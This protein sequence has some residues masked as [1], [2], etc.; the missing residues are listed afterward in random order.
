VKSP[1]HKLAL[2]VD[3]E[4]WYHSRR[5][6]DGE[7]ARTLPD[8]TALFRK[9]Y[10]SDRPAGEIIA[11]TLALLEL[12]ERHRCRATFFVLGEIARYY[13]DLVRRI[14]DA[15]HELACHG[16]YH[17]DMTVLGP[18]RFAEQL[19]EAVDLIQ[20]L[21]GLKPVGYRGPNLVYSPWAT[22]IL[23]D[24]GFLY[25]STV[26][27]SRPLGG[28]YAGWDKAPTH[29]YRASYDA[30]EEP[31]GSR[32]VE[33]PLPA[34][35]WIKLAGGSGITTRI[36]GYYWSLGALGHAIRRGNTAYYF[37]P[38]EV[39]TRPKAEGHRLRNALFLRR[40][41]PWMMRA[42]ERILRRFQGRIVTARESAE[43][44]TPGR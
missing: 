26:C 5:W 19:Q 30:I 9:L 16:L 41:G 42:V 18:E 39:G 27:G 4:E 21:T 17:V 23:E 34:F 8:S 13:P 40:T 2:S 35:P 28:K 10:G 37:H 25:D 36:L 24:Q 7:Q 6:V 29:P 15:G 32:L 11:P 12:F 31:G 33:L 22:R 20:G 43:G 38:W 3:L 14:A 1:D 44:L